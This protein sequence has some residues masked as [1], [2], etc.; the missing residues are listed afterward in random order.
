MSVRSA[1]TAMNLPTAATSQHPAEVERRCSGDFD[2]L[3][4]AGS[5]TSDNTSRRG[6]TLGALQKSPNCVGVVEVGAAAQF[7]GGMDV[8]CI[9]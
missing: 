6:G 5:A 8:R 7:C 1:A 3:C 9:S 2:H 4:K